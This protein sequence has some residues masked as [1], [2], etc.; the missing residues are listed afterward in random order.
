[1]LSGSSPWSE[2]RSWN[3]DASDDDEWLARALEEE[4]V[5][6]LSDEEEEGTQPELSAEDCSNPTEARAENQEPYGLCR[7]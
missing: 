7:K 5:M 6:S 1:M 2:A 3:K 4:S